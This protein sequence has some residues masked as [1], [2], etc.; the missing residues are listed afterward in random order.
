[1]KKD[2]FKRTVSVFVSATT[3]TLQCFPPESVRAAFW[4]ERGKYV[5]R[6]QQTPDN[7]LLAL[8]LPSPHVDSFYPNTENSVSL[9]LSFS[10]TVRPDAHGMTSDSS[11]LLRLVR[12]SFGTVRKMCPFGK[13]A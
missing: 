13:R 7:N 5:R 12:P 9:D 11:R 2:W 10:E 8:A 3:L 1:M 6:S 4:E